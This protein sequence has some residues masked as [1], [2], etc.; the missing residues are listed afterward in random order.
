MG[1]VAKLRGM[2]PGADRALQAAQI[3]ALL[4]VGYE[5]HNM[6]DSLYS[7]QRQQVR[8]VDEGLGEINRTLEDTERTMATRRCAP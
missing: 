8:V 4:W 7:G 6:T 3:A 1:L 2:V 5:L